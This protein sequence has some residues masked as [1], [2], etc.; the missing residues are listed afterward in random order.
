MHDFKAI[1]LAAGLGTRMNSSQP[2]ALHK[3]SGTPMITWIVNAIFKS[4]IN[5]IITIVPPNYEAFQNTLKGKSELAVQE[6]PKG[7]GHALLQSK[8]CLLYTSDAADE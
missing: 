7:S 1:I 3:L 5:E 6:S 2:K 8:A 4:R